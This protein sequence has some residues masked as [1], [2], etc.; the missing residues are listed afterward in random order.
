M[1]DKFLDSEMLKNILHKLGIHMKQQSTTTPLL[2]NSSVLSAGRSVDQATTRLGGNC[3]TDDIT[4]ALLRLLPLDK[5]R[6][7]GC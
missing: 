3:R 5:L 4:T 6:G 7:R 2:I 1:I